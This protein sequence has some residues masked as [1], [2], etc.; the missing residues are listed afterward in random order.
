MKIN[1]FFYPVFVVNHAILTT[2]KFKVIGFRGLNK[3]GTLNSNLNSDILTSGKGVARHHQVLLRVTQKRK[4]N[5]FLTKR[6][7]DF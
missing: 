1:G 3:C 7:T 6:T 5:L 4:R 2:N